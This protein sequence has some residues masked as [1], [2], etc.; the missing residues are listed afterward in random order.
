MAGGAH[1]DCEPALSIE[2]ETLP[3]DPAGADTEGWRRLRAA[4]HH[5]R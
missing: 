2:G 5:W 1:A 3:P 4:T